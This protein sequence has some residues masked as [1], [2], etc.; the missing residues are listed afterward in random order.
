MGL[1]ENVHR[2]GGDL[3]PEFAPGHPVGRVHSRQHPNRDRTGQGGFLVESAKG[4]AV[5]RRIPD[6][7]LDGKEGPQVHEAGKTY[8]NDELSFFRDAPRLGRGWR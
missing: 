4:S 5:G 7:N 8:N 1:V 2:N 6:L 3:R